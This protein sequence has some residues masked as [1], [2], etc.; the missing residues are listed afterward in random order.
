MGAHSDDLEKLHQA[1]RVIG[2][3]R[4]SST[5]RIKRAYRRLAR[6]WHPDKWPLV[7]LLTAAASAI[8]GD[9]FWRWVLKGWWL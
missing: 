1:Y 5:L 4:D 7:P 2:V 6:T 9:R 8:Y 3:A